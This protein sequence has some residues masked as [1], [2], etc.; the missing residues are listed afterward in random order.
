VTDNGCLVTNGQV[1]D[2]DIDTEACPTL[3]EKSQSFLRENKAAGDPAAFMKHSSIHCHKN[4][5]PIF[6][7]LK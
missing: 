5:V 4:V 3:A 6:S 7:A 2:A 1:Q